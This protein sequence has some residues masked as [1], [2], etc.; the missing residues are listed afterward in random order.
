MDGMAGRGGGGKCWPDSA[1]SRNGRQG[2]R[3][4]RANSE[5]QIAKPSI[6]EKVANFAVRLLKKEELSM[7]EGSSKITRALIDRTESI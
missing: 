2:R 4:G 7:G 5:W 6:P 1:V 3:P